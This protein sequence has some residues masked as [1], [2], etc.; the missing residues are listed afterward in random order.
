MRLGKPVQQKD[1]R[2]RPEAAQKN[3]RFLRLHFDRFKIFKCDC[4]RHR[5]ASARR[6]K[7]S[8]TITHNTLGDRCT[9]GFQS[10]LSPS[11]RTWAIASISPVQAARLS[12]GTV[13]WIVH[14]GTPGEFDRG[15]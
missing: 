4:A 9:A 1:G 10:P 3:R 14:D 7:M 8:R 11:K 15:A 5:I 12:C 6:L 13:V 2:S